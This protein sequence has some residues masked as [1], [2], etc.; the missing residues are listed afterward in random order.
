MMRNDL[1]CLED[2][3]LRLAVEYGWNLEAW[4]VF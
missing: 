3:L 2:P 4:A 1:S